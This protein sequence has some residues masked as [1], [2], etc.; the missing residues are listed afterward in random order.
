MAPSFPSGHRRQDGW[1]NNP[2]K[3]RRVRLAIE[4]ALG[5]DPRVEA[6][7]DLVRNHAEY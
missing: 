7:L 4:A 1:R 6:I 3:T 2:V 5:D